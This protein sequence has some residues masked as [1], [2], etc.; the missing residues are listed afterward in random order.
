MNNYFENKLRILQE[1]V[2][3]CTKCDLHKTRKQTVFARGNPLANLTIVA[4]SPGITEDEIGLPL[5]GASGQLLNFALKEI[6]LKPD[7]DVYVCNIIKCRPPNNRTPTDEEINCCFDWL[8]QQ[9]QLTNTKVLITLGNTATQSITNTPFGISKVRGKWLRYYK[10]PVMPSW[11][12]SYL[13][14]SGGEKSNSFK[15]FINDLKLA[16]I[17]VKEL[18]SNE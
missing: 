7:N 8:E 9:L 17:K 18:S 2:A 16:T 1:Q 6:G 11:H 15:E 10:I 4:E 3:T 5:V 12:P 13:L 14:R